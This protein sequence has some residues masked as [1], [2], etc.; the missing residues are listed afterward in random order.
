MNDERKIFLYIFP[1]YNIMHL[2]ISHKRVHSRIDGYSLFFL[3]RFLLMAVI[4]VKKT[5]IVR[6]KVLM[7]LRFIFLFIVIGMEWKL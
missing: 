2:N 5:T 3:F 1:Y 7:E 6:Q 4:C